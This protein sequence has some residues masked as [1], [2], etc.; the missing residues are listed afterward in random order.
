M[1][2]V[3]PAAE[4]LFV[5]LENAETALPERWV[6]LRARAEN[7]FVVAFLIAI[8]L[9]WFAAFAYAAYRFLF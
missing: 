7:V 8:Q 6:R 5:G 1:A 9:A 2:T 3:E 4:E